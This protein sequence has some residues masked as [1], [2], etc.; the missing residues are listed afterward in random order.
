MN[1]KLF[2]TERH[3][4]KWHQPAGIFRLKG[5][6]LLTPADELAPSAWTSA[7]NTMFGKNGMGIHGLVYYTISYN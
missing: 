5:R 1:E 2:K 7:E 3:G 6:S 4:I